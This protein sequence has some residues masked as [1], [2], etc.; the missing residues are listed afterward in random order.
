MLAQAYRWVVRNGE[1]EGHA[2][3]MRDAASVHMTNVAVIAHS[4]I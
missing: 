2:A 1:H 3:Q 4:I